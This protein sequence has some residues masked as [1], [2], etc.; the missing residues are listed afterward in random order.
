MCREI[1]TGKATSSRF[2]AVQAG[3]SKIKGKLQKLLD[4]YLEDQVS[5]QSLKLETRKTE[6]EALLA[7]PKVPPLLLAGVYREQII[8]LHEAL[9]SEL[10]TQRQEAAEIVR[11]LIETIILTPS[12]DGMRIDVCGD[13]A[14]ILT[15]ASGTQKSANAGMRSRFDPR[16]QFEMVAGACFPRCHKLTFLFAANVICNI[17]NTHQFAA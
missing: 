8:R 15:I 6:L 5:K 3:L 1:I 11:S 2:H 7:C 10:E 17:E 16:S 4:L 12:D 13:L 9:N 14:G